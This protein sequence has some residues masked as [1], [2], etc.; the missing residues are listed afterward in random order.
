MGEGG[1]KRSEKGGEKRRE[2]EV[3]KKELEA[4]KLLAKSLQ[5]LEKLEGRG[6]EEK[7][8]MKREEETVKQYEER[9]E[10]IQIEA[11]KVSLQVLMEL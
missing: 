2:E 8:K 3:K 9:I 7:R 4:G 10:R 5:I 6:L 11:I 1:S